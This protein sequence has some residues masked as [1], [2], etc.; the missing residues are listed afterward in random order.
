MAKLE[1]PLKP[2]LMASGRISS[3]GTINLSI[4]QCYQGPFFH[5]HNKNESINL[6]SAY[7]QKEM[8]RNILIFHQH[9]W[10]M[11]TIK[12]YNIKYLW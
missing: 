8:N 7:L 12:Y 1:H 2:K 6:Q 10:W 11:N 3:Y 9:F 5:V 4:L